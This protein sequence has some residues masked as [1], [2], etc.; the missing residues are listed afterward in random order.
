MFSNFQNQWWVAIKLRVRELLVLLLLTSSLFAQGK[1]TGR[2]FDGENGGTLI[3]VNVFI[4]GK[5]IGA[6]T[7]IDGIYIIQGVERGE[8]TLVF[9]MIGYSK[10][11]VTEVIINKDET[12]KIDVTLLPESFQ[13]EEVVITAKL[14]VDNEAS[15]LIKRQKSLSVSDAI[16]AEMISRSG[17]GNAADAVS[18]IT[19]ASVVGGK[20][21]YVRGLGD[22][23]SSTHMNGTELPSADPD[24]RSFNLDLLPSN[25]L[26]NITTVK[27]FTPDKP[28]NFSGGI[29]DVGTRN[30]PEK[31]SFKISTASS[32]NSNTSFNNNFLT[33]S[34]GN[35]DWLGFDD[36]ARS[37][38][39]QLTDG[40]YKIP[41]PNESRSDAQ[42]AAE[43][44]R[45]S[46][47]LNPQMWTV[48]K[49]A[50]LNQNFSIS[51]GNQENVFGSPFGYVASISYMRG[52]SYYNNGSVGR[53]ELAGPVET[54]DELNN[55]MLLKDAKASEEALWGGLVNLAYKVHPN[56]DLSAKA[57]ISQSGESI[58]RYQ[59]G[60]W[61]DQLGENPV[62]E[63]RSL[64]Y[65]ERSLRTYQASG[66]HMFP[67]FFGLRVDWT[68][69]LSTSEQDEPDLRFFSNDY[70]IED[71]DTS[72]AISINNYNAPTRF[73]RTLQEDNRSFK[74]DF[75]LPFKQWSELQAKIKFGTSFTEIGREFNERRFEIRN[76]GGA[77]YNG[78]PEEYFIN[79][80]GII[81]IDSVRNRYYFGNYLFDASALRNNYTG[82]QIVSAAYGMVELPLDRSLKMIAG[83]RYET[84]SM[85]VASADTSVQ[86][87]ELNNEDILPALSLIYGIN[88][89]MNLRFA[90]GK[91]LA[92]PNF[93]E[94]APFRS[95][96]F[97]GDFQFLGNP[98]LER[99]LIDNLD[100]RF[101]WFPAPGEIVAVS[102]FYKIFTNPI[103]RAFNPS[104]EVISFQNV[105]EGTSFGAEFEFRKNLGTLTDLLSNFLLNTNFSLIY[106]KVDIPEKE[107]NTL[108]KI[109]DPAAQKSRPLF[110]QSPYIVNIELAYQNNNSGTTAGLFY[111]VAGERLAE[112]TLGATPD[113][114][115]RP[116]QMLDLNIS[117]RIY[118]GID[119]KF[120]IKNILDSKTRNVI[121]YKGKEYTY[122]E[123]S[124]GRSFTVGL[125]YSL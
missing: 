11:S 43:L 28:G 55:Y 53:W 78:D 100:L 86:K 44:D 83:L 110:G 46:G 70:L 12:V 22:R 80:S 51:F 123:Y 40:E 33:Y 65:T 106:S 4:E 107:Y 42:K 103:E 66:E 105:P 14:A 35:N 25:L 9:S 54:A 116:K 88:Q 15:L 122:S 95:F 60:K 52:Y 7:D 8:H 79:Q 98:D 114:Y 99:T 115:E 84:T 56:H 18:K 68:G 125:S 62:Y 20:Y 32:Y 64:L 120:G 67:E 27:S 72:F 91:T 82:D 61:P 13:T 76:A 5:N 17:M 81:R 41:T 97:L 119:M 63:T 112:V 121:E 74:A 34:G 50:P 10:K 47:M 94:M 75:S 102:A 48:T 124:N 2:V 113:V 26:D 109:F 3:G 101:E 87:G 49:K 89:N 108:I 71:N 16:S 59:T 29:V 21:V 39:G 69:T 58:S 77:H 93:R 38:P 1:V 96:E 92:R 90:Y 111:N 19:G 73:F 31:M 117:Q 30:Y 6:A 23:Y 85:E 104:T 118:E 24:K 36:G 57:I 45:V 37:L